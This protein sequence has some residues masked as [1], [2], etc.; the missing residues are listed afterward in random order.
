MRSPVRKIQNIWF[1]SVT[2]TNDGVS[3]KKTYSK[4]EKHRFRVSPTMGYV[5][6]TTIGLN[7]IYDRYVDCYD[8][9]FNPPEGTMCFVDIIPELDSDGYLA[10][11]EVPEYELD[12]TQAVDDNDDPITRTEYVTEP[13][14]IIKRVLNTQRGVVAR[15]VLERT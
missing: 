10:T 8:R 6:G 7:L 12:G 13:D 11:R 4:P 1:C 2:E 15:F 5:R 3:L 9:S 14:Y